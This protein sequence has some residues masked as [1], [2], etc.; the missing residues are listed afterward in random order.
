MSSSSLNGRYNFSFKPN[1]YCQIN[2][3]QFDE[4]IGDTQNIRTPTHRRNYFSDSSTDNTMGRAVILAVGC[5]LVVCL[6]MCQVQ[7]QYSVENT[8]FIWPV[9]DYPDPHSQEARQHQLCRR[10]SISSVCD[11]NGIIQPQQGV[12]TTDWSLLH[13]FFSFVLYC[14]F[15]RAVF[16]LF[17]FFAFVYISES[18]RPSDGVINCCRLVSSSY[19]KIKKWDFHQR[20]VLVALNGSSKYHHSLYPPPST[21]SF[22]IA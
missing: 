17:C 18:V 8:P 16:F 15:L 4:Q 10:N 13:I 12:Y 19:K 6:S 7:A 22:E 14:F 21:V 5:C 2:Y 11:P 1:L 3:V 9:W 20:S